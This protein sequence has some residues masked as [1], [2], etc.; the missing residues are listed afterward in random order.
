P[1]KL[2]EIVLRELS[3]A[4]VLGHRC[5]HAREMTV[6]ARPQR[7]ELVPRRLL[8][9]LPGDPR[10]LIVAGERQV[11]LKLRPHEALMIVRRGV[12]EMTD[13]L[14]R[15]PFTRRRPSAARLVVNR[16]E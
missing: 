6:E 10:V 16:E 11:I 3:R 15:R 4:Q 13:D 2:V 5:H 14:A 7:D 1:R 8:V 9:T 12:D